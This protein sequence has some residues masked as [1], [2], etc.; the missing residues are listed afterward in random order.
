MKTNDM[1]SGNFCLKNS[2]NPTIKLKDWS[3][4]PANISYLEKLLR[5]LLQDDCPVCVPE[6]MVKGIAYK[7]EHMRTNLS[8]RL[9]GDVVVVKKSTPLAVLANAWRALR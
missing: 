7:S 6:A 3:S 5:Y 1:Y 2:P 8:Y 9:I 4:T